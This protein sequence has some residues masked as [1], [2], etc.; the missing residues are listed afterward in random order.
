MPAFCS[1]QM[2][3]QKEWAW[4]DQPTNVSYVHFHMGK[5]AVARIFS[6]WLLLPEQV[7]HGS[8][9]IHTLV[10]ISSLLKEEMREL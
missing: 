3:L 1:E 10:Q 8:F 7:W 2:R 9:H 6:Q 5:V 4:G